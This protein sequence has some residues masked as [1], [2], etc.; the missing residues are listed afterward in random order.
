MVGMTRFERATPSSQAR[1]A[2][3]LRYIPMINI[4]LFWYGSAPTVLRLSENNTQLFSSAES[5]CATSREF[6]L[7]VRPKLR[8]SGAL[9]CLS[10]NNTQLF[11]SAE[12]YIPISKCFI[13]RVPITKS[14]V[15]TTFYLLVAPGS[16]HLSIQWTFLILNQKKISSRGWIEK[17]SKI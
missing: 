1:C 14:T 10:Q 4:Q 12:C 8:F 13:Y 2:T 7:I 9:P 16:I 15:L 17:S 11:C 5:N 3:K 6:Y